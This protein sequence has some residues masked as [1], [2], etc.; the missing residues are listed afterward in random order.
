M[1]KNNVLKG[2]ILLV[3]MF[4]MNNSFSQKN[5]L[6]YRDIL[7]V[8]ADTSLLK[9]LTIDG[10]NGPILNPDFEY[11]DNIRI[12]RLLYFSDTNLISGYLVFPTNSGK[13]PCII[14]NRDGFGK[15][16]M[17]TDE[18]A[19]KELATIA[20]WGYL[21]IASQYRGSG[22]DEG[23]D[24]FGGNDIN[25]VLTLIDV[26]KQVNEADTT[27]I[28]MYGW[29]R[30]GMMTYLALSKT[31]KIKAAFVGGGLSDLLYNAM[32][33]NDS[34]ETVYPEIIPDFISIS[35]EA[36]KQ[37]SAVYFC[38]NI[39]KTTSILLLHGTADS[40][41]APQ[42][43]L[44]LSG[45]FLKNKIPHK[46]IMYEGGTNKLPEYKKEVNM[47]IKKWFHKYLKN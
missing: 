32:A 7:N 41:A 11:I 4:F 15:F 26:L 18:F 22:S 14:Y 27:K 8:N 39:C 37:R 30:G 43:V 25:D 42:T 44:N 35:E 20:S 6:A 34:V 24:E 47:E 17:I 31:D 19:M 28:G 38:E 36:M 33:G 3:F 9:L 13:L 2:I 46:L 1:Q 16:G 12:E 40:L 23:I 5:K 10:P 29:H 21:V 45:E